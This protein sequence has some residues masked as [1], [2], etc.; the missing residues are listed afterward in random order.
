MHARQITKDQYECL[1]YLPWSLGINTADSAFQ[2]EIGSDD[3]WTCCGSGCSGRQRSDVPVLRQRSRMLRISGSL[4]HATHVNQRM[5][6]LVRRDLNDDSPSTSPPRSRGVGVEVLW[7]RRA[8]ISAVHHIPRGTLGR[9]AR[10]HC[11]ATVC[12]SCHRLLIG[13]KRTCAFI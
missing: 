3:I 11:R 6:F 12:V 2:C 1:K 7:A 10:R 5:D 4:L 9:I 8:R 13:G